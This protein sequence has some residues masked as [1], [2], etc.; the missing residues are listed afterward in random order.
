MLKIGLRNNLLYLLML[1][2]FTFF[3]KVD[4][5]MMNQIIGFKSSLLLTFLMFFGE[6][7]AGIIIYLYQISFFKKQKDTEKIFMGIKLI[8]A[9]SELSY[10][11][12][13]CKIFIL[14]F[15]A[16]YF[17]FIEYTMA[18]YYLPQYDNISNSL[19][20]R[21][22]GMLTIS[23]AFLCCYLL[24]LP[25]LKH[26][27]FSLSIIFICFISVL[28]FEYYFKIIYEKSNPIYLTLVISLNFITHFFTAFKDVIEKYL[29]EIDYINPFKLIMLEG[30]FGCIL[31][32]IYSFI[33]EP[34]TKVI[35]IYDEHN[36]KFILLIIFLFLFSFFSGGRNAYRIITNKI[37]SPMT[38]TLTDCA[39]DPLLITYFFIFENDFSIRGIQNIIYFIINLII[40][41][42]IVFFGCVYNEL[43]ILFCFGLEHNTHHFVTL[44][45]S[46]PS[47][48]YIFIK[49]EIIL[50]QEKV[51]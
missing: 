28:F 29:L 35:S 23:A 39:L 51:N 26:Q 4:L 40:S 49:K 17:D 27:I 20:K 22:N 34:F 46:R 43:F 30:I 48:N 10:P 12:S 15:I 21:L 18:T 3:R 9:S 41:I 2:I 16:S 13:D 50:N 1:T 14:I 32:S 7:F 6:F 25:I 33:E 44:R 42:I 11:D 31:T 24:K 8:Q 19:D 36:Y 38:R 45:A 47:N 37:Y 5:I